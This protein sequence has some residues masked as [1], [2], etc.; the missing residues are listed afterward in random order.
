MNPEPL[1]WGER[2]PGHLEQPQETGEGKTGSGGTL[3]KTTGENVLG[4][5]KG[6]KC[7]EMSWNVRKKEGKKPNS[8][9]ETYNNSCNRWQKLV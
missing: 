9:S 5:K 7:L 2:R 3:F 4:R 6:A 1:C 8:S